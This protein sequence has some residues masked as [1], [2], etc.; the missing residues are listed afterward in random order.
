M[1]DNKNMEKAGVEETEVLLRQLFH[2]KRYET[3]EVARMTRNKQNIMR[4][5]REVSRNK[6]KSLGDL[7]EGSI[8]WFFA[9][10]KYGV[11]LLFVAFASLQYLGINARNA[12]HNRTGI[13]TAPSTEQFADYQQPAS[14]DGHKKI[15]PKI[16]SNSR[17]FPVPQGN[18]NVMMTGYETSDGEQPVG[19]RR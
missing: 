7:L 3:P 15:Y 18:D 11:A 12:E 16:P 10:P 6:R 19:P 13:Y 5:V 17:L 4:Q 9:E 8:P 1:M 14:E 2:L